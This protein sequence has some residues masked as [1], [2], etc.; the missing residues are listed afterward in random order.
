MGALK[1]MLSRGLEL[2]ALAMA[3]LAAVAM[4]GIVGIITT[5]VIMRRFFNSP[6]HITEDMVGLM[7]SAMLFLAMPLVTLRAEH[8]R[9][10]IVADALQS[11]IPRLLR[12]AAMLV[13]VVFFGWIL[14][15]SIP[16]F[17]FAW[18]RTLK[19]ETARVLLY[20]WMAALPLSVAVTWVIFAGRL[21]GLLAPERPHA[22]EELQ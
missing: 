21:L 16:W 15:E 14:L 19:S 18:K 20:P 6:V 2:L 17:E 9:V 13:G 10:S 12:T 8:V 5:S 1:H 11:R 22:P 3:L 4:V 7:L